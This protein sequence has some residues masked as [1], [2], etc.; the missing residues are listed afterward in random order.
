MKLKHLLVVFMLAIVIVT[1]GGCALT[2]ASNEANGSSS[3]VVVVDSEESVVKDSQTTRVDDVS[4]EGS[5]SE[6]EILTFDSSMLDTTDMFSNRDLEQEVDLT[7]ATYVELVSNQTMTIEEEGVYVFSGNVTNTMIF[8]EAEDE[9]KVQL[10]LHGVTIINEDQPAIY[11]KSG[12]KVFVTTTLSDNLLEVTGDYSADGDTNLDAVIYSKSDLVLNGLGSLVIT[13]HEGNGVTSKDDLKVTGGTYLI[14]S[15]EDSLEANDSIRIYDGQ[16]TIVTEKDGLHSEN[17]DD[18]SL[19]YIYI[20]NGTIKIAAADDA[21]HGTSVIQIDGGTIDIVTSSEGIEANYVLIN[22][23]IINIYAT[24]DGI[25]A[26]QKSNLDVTIEVNGGHITI[27]MANGD[28][29]GFDS[30]GDLFINGGF[31]DVTGGS[32]FDVDGVAEFNS[33][34]VKVNGEEVS[35][36]PASQMGGRKRG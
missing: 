14:T 32:T 12:D 10:V 33:G 9:A 31:I 28:T 29:D 18:E 1:L 24:D 27:N 3:E 11:V 5:N 34:T 26:S 36:L 22:D 19:G 8:V 15:Q 13:S 30:N 4:S 6:V 7:E 21:I 20:Q 25:N 16:L 17:E 2:Q 23:G 35:E